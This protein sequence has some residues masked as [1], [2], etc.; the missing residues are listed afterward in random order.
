MG[1][2]ATALARYLIDYC[3]LPTPRYPRLEPRRRKD[4][5]ALR[6]DDGYDG[7]IEDS[8][9]YNDPRPRR[10]ELTS[11]GYGRH[12]THNT[13]NKRVRLASRD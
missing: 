3:D 13:G 10:R 12:G 2:L 9:V 11:N 6:E 7:D 5:H 4:F 1:A 8:E